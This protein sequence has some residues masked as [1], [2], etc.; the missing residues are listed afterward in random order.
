MNSA[1]VY[2]HSDDSHYDLESDEHH[3]HDTTDHK[4]I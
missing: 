2:V 3:D 1:I 4:A